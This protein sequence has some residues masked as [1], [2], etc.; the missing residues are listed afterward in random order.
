MYLAAYIVKE[1]WAWNVVTLREE[2]N[3][4]SE[5]C[6]D[7]LSRILIQKKEVWRRLHNGGIP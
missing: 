2:L 5:D 6:I 4:K 7:L 3:T 1:I